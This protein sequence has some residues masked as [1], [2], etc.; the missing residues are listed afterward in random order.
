MAASLSAGLAGIA[1]QIEP[2][3]PTTGNGYV[4]GV[5]NGAAL[6]DTM[7]GAIDALKASDHATEW[8]SPR[9]VQAYSSTRATQLAAFEGDDLIAERRRFFELG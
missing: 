9:F 8:L 1:G 4:P 5:G 2:T 6:I 7:Q 3:E